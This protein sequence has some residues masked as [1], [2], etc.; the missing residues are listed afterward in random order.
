MGRL[1]DILRDGAGNFNKTWNA[2][3]AADDFGPVPRGVYICHVTKGELES[4][5]SNH[6]PGYKLEFTIMEG[7]FKGR[8]LWTDLWLTPAA[9]PQSKRDLTKLGIKS[10][11]QLEQPLP[12]WI[13]CKVTA[14]VHK[15]DHEIERNKVQCFD[16]IGIEKPEPDPFAPRDGSDAP[17]AAGDANT[18]FDPEF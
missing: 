11:E 3:A 7:H 12:R 2:T 13:R 1:S 16:V 10:P 15:G 9:L 17:E 8:K 5:R 4:S 6:T 18:L 14:V